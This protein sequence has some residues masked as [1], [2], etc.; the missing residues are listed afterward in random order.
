MLKAHSDLF[1][2]VIC[3]IREPWR[4]KPTTKVEVSSVSFKWIGKF[5]LANGSTDTTVALWDMRNLKLKVHS[6]ENHGDEII[7]VEWSPFNQAIVASGLLKDVSMCGIS[8]KL[9]RNK[10]L[11]MRKMDHQSCCSFMVN[12][13]TRFQTSRGILIKLGLS[14]PL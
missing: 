7:Q 10:T 8:P 3:D 6:F 2:S 9:A 12:K 13:L 14:P 5:V 11:R 1:A 4:K